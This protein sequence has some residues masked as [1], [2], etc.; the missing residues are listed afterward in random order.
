MKFRE[1]GRRR[2]G[3][4]GG[5]GGGGNHHYQLKTTINLSCLF[6]SK[7]RRRRTISLD[8][9]RRR[10]RRRYHHYQNPQIIGGEEKEEEEEEEEEAAV[11]TFL[12]F[13][14]SSSSPSFQCVC[15]C[16]CKKKEPAV[17]TYS[18]SDSPSTLARILFPIKKSDGK[19]LFSG[20]SK[21]IKKNENATGESARMRFH[22]VSLMGEE[23]PSNRSSQQTASTKDAECGRHRNSPKRRDICSAT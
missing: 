16:A 18:V 11:S 3:G 13:I 9:E 8:G 21:P 17:T 23:V 14:T 15:V 4:G 5:G 12:H 22:L 10:R 20:L 19:K 1:S 6:S 7:R 2:Q